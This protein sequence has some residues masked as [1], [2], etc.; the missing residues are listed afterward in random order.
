MKRQS[1]PANT[2]SIID[3]L[4]FKHKV[5]HNHIQHKERD[6]SD[7]LSTLDVSS[8]V[9]EHCLNGCLLLIISINRKITPHAQPLKTDIKTKCTQYV[10]HNN[11]DKT[12]FIILNSYF[13]EIHLRAD[14]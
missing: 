13:T 2:I 11:I 3:S 1:H 8:W 9:Y 7:L 12:K 6:G 4:V 5:V 10:Q 14:R